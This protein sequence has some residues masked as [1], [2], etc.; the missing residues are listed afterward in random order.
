MA[1]G[2]QPFGA[3]RG[4]PLTGRLT[5]MTSNSDVQPISLVERRALRQA[6]S[7]N[8]AALTAAQERA[9]RQLVIAALGLDLPT[10]TR[11]L[12]SRRLQQMPHLRLLPGAERAA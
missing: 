8:A 10:L 5:G 3:A 4:G 2:S 11:H 1:G 7:S 12:R 6:N 9:Y